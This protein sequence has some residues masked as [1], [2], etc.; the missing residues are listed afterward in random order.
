MCLQ[1]IC[2]TYITH[3]WCKFVFNTLQRHLLLKLPAA[4]DGPLQ[5]KTPSLRCVLFARRFADV[6]WRQLLSRCVLV[7]LG[8]KQC[9]DEVSSDYIGAVR[10]RL[11]KHGHTQT[12]TGSWIIRETPVSLGFTAADLHDKISWRINLSSFPASLF[13][14]CSGE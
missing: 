4:Q 3:M 8:T 2:L 10:H 5:R 11:H 13:I 1:P 14:R 12:H 9:R 7:I 6:V